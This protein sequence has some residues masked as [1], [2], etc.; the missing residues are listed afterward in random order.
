MSKTVD[1][2]EFDFEHSLPAGREYFTLGYLARLWDCSEDNVQRLIDDGELEVAVDLAP[3]KSTHAMQRIFRAS[4]VALLN[5]R[6]S[7]VFERN[8]KKAV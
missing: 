3:K 4:I 6:K 7:G 8:K 5:R 1:Q 2:P